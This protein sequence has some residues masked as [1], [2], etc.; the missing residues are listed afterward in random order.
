MI[1]LQCTK[2]S[3][4]YTLGM[5]VFVTVL[6]AHNMDHSKVYSIICLIFVGS[7]GNLP[8][9]QKPWNT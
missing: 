3:K 4:T 5:N 8:V 1:R 2:N 9:G 6:D 7:W